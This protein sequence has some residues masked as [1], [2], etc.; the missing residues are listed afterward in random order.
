MRGLSAE[1]LQSLIMSVGARGAKRR[2]TPVEVGRRFKKAV[3]SGA[4]LQECAD[5]VQLK[6]SSMV[7]RF[8]RLLKLNPNIQHVV[9]WGQSD[10]TISFSS[11]WKLTQFN[12]KDQTQACN[13]ILEHQLSSPEVVQLIQLRVRSGKPI[14]ECVKGV[15]RMRPQ[16]ERRHVFIGAIT[17]E[18]LRDRLSAMLQQ[19]RDELLTRAV[20]KRYAALRDFACRLGAS[21][22]TI[23]G[24]DEVANVLKGNAADFETAINAELLKES[25]KV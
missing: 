5:A 21:R 10:A 24:G 15:L 11:A 17:S 25:P 2:Y 1:E 19:D 3:D 4:S 6:G 9:D 14:T 18:R 13:A 20:R 16:I 12:S 8:M 22:F 23:V 7:S